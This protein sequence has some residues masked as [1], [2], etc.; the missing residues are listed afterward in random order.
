MKE[1][2]KIIRPYL[3][4]LIEEHKDSWKVQLIIV[5]KFVSS[6]D[7]GDEQKLFTESNNLEIMWGTD[8][9]E[10]TNKASKLLLEK[11]KESIQIM[12]SGHN[13][14]VSKGK[15]FVDQY[16]WEG[17]SWPQKQGR[18]WRRFEKNNLTIA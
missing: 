14:R 3:K 9:D 8:A 6:N 18:D 10:T 13:K 1:Y 15:P 16:N 2:F 12:K 5:N 4:K 11:S 7:N 17:I